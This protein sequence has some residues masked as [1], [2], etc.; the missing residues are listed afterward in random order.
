MVV[1]DTY[2]RFKNAQAPAIRNSE[3]G[4]MYVEGEHAYPIRRSH[5]F[6]WRK[7]RDPGEEL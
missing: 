7:G 4:T 2:R 6:F 5:S 1:Q 3:F